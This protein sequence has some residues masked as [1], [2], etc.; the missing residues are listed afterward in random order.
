MLKTI[1]ELAAA[2][3]W[4]VPGRFGLARLLGP[5]YSLRCLVFHDISSV[6]S[7]FTS[8]MAVSTAPSSFELALDFVRRYYTPVRLEDVL[9]ASGGGPLPSRAVLLTFDDGYASVMLWAVPLCA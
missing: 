5:S 2:A 8:G 9:A 6:K 7:A 3:S 1:S 4:R